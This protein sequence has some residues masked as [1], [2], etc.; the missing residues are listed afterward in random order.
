MAID[1]EEMKWYILYTM[2]QHEKKISAYLKKIGV[3]HYLPLIPKTRKWSDRT[4]VIEFPLFPGYLFTYTD[5]AEG[6]IKALQH[7]GAKAYIRHQGEPAFM[8]GDEIEN[9]KM[10]VEHS[11]E[12]QSDPDTNFPP[13]QTVEVRYGPL[14]GV[15]GVVER[16]KNKN[17]I[18]VRVP[19]LNRMV[20]AE[21]DVVDLNKVN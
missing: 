21:V 16:V 12:I 8:T 7:P 6:R 15:R 14:K 10:L 1:A 17:R 9:L 18:Y 20:S 3:E 13:G 11:R 19:M 4:K 5:W 2:P